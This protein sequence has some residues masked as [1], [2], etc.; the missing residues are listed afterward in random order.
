MP[1][2]SK[3][4][5]FASGGSCPARQAAIS[6]GP[7]STSRELSLPGP[8]SRHMAPT[9]IS[10]PQR[11]RRAIGCDGP[12]HFFRSH[13]AQAPA[14]GARQG[15]AGRNWRC[16]HPPPLA[17]EKAARRILAG[18][19]FP[20]GFR[21][22]GLLGHGRRAR[23]PRRSSRACMSS[24]CVIG[25]P[26]VVGKGQPLV[27]RRWTPETTLI[28]GGFGTQI[29]SPDS[30]EVLPERLIVPLL[31]FDSIGYRLGYGG[32]FYDRTLAK[33]RALGRGACDRLCLCR[34]G[35]RCRAPRILRPAARLDGDRGIAFARLA[36]GVMRLLFCGDLVGRAG[37]DGRHRD[38][39][40]AAPRSRARFRGRQWRER[41][42]RLRHHR[43]DLPAALWRR[44]RCRHHRQ[45]CLGPEGAR[46]S[47]STAIPDCCGRRIFPP[48]RRAAAS[49]CSR[50]ASG[51]RVVV[52]NVMGRLFMDA[53]DDP[54][55]VALERS[56]G[57]T[58][59]ARRRMPSW[60]TCMP[61]RPARRRPSAY[62]LD[63]KASLVVGTHTHV[64]TADARDPARRHRLS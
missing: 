63:G 17:G 28:P 35:G 47:S 29:P 62:H 36:S 12:A 3:L 46:P 26:V 45:S 22:L 37:R 57:R 59:S 11:I 39:A 48:A 61:R 64:P 1:F 9:C 55:A 25:L 32:G 54:F 21:G 31:A 24:G 15:S 51:K 19:D 58:A 7:I 50:R 14:P 38:A 27:F 23:L 16:D 43:E 6:L 13:P 52:I 5:K 42:R 60:S 33:L 56:G 53:L 41:R 18:L 4:P 8:W 2:A 49:G 10:R 30:P 20:P 44:R 34:A 40:A